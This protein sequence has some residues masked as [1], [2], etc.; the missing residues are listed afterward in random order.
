MI[1]QLGLSVF[2]TLAIALS[3]LATARVRKWSSVFGL[4]SEPFWFY[5]SYQAHQWG[6]VWVTCICTLS[7][8][9]GFYV[10]WVRR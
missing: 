6:A 2:T 8:T 5:S 10:G 3:Q 7:F 4:L 1:D 9:Y